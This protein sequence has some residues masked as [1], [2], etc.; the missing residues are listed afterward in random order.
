MCLMLFL[1]LPKEGLF[2][3]ETFKLF[4]RYIYGRN[5]TISCLLNHIYTLYI[6]IKVIILIMHP[7]MFQVFVIKSHMC[8]GNI[9][10]K[11]LHFHRSKPI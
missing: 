2:L 8:K 10:I 9:N 4:K 1:K 11:L 6:Y 7:R 5:V 3:T